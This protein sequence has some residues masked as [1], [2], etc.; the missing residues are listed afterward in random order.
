MTASFKSRGQFGGGRWYGLSSDLTNLLVFR[1]VLKRK[2]HFKTQF[3][4][5]SAD[6][7]SYQLAVTF[8]RPIMGDRMTWLSWLLLAMV[9]ISHRTKALDSG[10]IANDM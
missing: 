8:V 10:L 4:K 1:S 3:T 5:T 9:V 2:R 6:R 7:S